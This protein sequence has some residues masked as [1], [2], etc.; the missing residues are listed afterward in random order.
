MTLPMFV[1]RETHDLKFADAKPQTLWTLPQPV[2]QHAI[3]SMRLSEGDQLQLCDGN[4]TRVLASIA[5]TTSALVRVESVSHDES[6]RVKLGL[7]QALAKSG[8]DEQAIEMATEIG[9]DT[10]IPWQSHRSIVQWKGNKAEKALGKWRDIVLA[11]TEQSRRSF[12]PEVIAMKTSKQ[13]VSWADERIKERDIVLVLHQD[14]TDTWGEFEAVASQASEN[15]TIWVVVG[16]EGG[17]SDEEV[18]ALKNVGAHVCVIGHNILRASSAGSVALTL[19]S[20]V[21]GR[22]V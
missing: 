2:A 5:D 8:R 13:L 11:A 15:S 10:V 14:A 21:T 4:G 22:Y 19:L 6:P 20:R 12:M 16:P 7:V 1:V 3:K 17:I 9:V 18:D